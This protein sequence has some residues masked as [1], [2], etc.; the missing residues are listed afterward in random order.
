[1]DTKMSKVALVAILVGAL[2]GIVHYSKFNTTEQ[3]TLTAQASG[4]CAIS[5]SFTGE[6]RRN[7]TAAMQS[8][9]CTTTH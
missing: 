9:N 3:E 8:F 5:Q 7:V 4:A 2:G 1:M 6:A